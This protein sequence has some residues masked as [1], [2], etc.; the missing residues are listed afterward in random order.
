MPAPPGP[1]SCKRLTL[2]CFV[3][4]RRFAI[5]TAISRSW[6]LTWSRGSPVGYVGA[7]SASLREE[8]RED[9]EPDRVNDKVERAAGKVA[10]A[11]ELMR[12]WVSIVSGPWECRELIM[13]ARK[14]LSRD[15]GVFRSRATV[16]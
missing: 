1:I 16:S 6:Q 11:A 8:A 10:L 12:S 7:G 2:R 4:L 5:D 9:A 14:R 13:A 3:S 15:F